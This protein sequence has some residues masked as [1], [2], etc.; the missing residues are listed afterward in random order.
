[1]HR[2]E[3][4]NGAQDQERR[5]AAN[6]VEAAMVIDGSRDPVASRRFDDLISQRTTCHRGDHGDEGADCS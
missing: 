2:R 3:V 5:D 6:F 1:M 4:E